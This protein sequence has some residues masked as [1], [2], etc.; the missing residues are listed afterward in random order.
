MRRNIKD[1]PFLLIF[2][3]YDELLQASGKT[4]SDYL[5]K[6]AEFQADHRSYYHSMVRCIV[7]SRETLIDKAAIPAGCPVLRLC[8]FDEERIGAWCRIWNQANEQYFVNHHVDRLEIASAGK[9]REL[10]G[11]PLLLL[12]LALYE[13]NG[14]RLQEQ[15]DISRAKLYDKLIQETGV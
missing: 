3:G 6:I 11:Q 9:V 12:M 1:K 4:H 5:N 8:E 2:D 7:T 14:N 15:G 10:A 13:M